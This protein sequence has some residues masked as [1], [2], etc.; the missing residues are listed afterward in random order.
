MECNSTEHNFKI[1]NSFWQNKVPE[2][3]FWDYETATD[4]GASGNSQ[5]DATIFVSVILHFTNTPHT[6]FTWS[7]DVIHLTC[8][9]IISYRLWLALEN[10]SDVAFHIQ[11]STDESK[12]IH[13]VA[14]LHTDF[15]QII[16]NLCGQDPQLCTILFTYFF[17]LHCWG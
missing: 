12:V 1:K 11:L 16:E 9:N 13:T 7:K 6:N 8:H 14:S 3:R 17:Q 2:E 5:I 10:I 4:I 15:A